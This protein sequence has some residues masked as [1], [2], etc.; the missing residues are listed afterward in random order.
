MVDDRELILI[1]II[2]LTV[3]MLQK[4]NDSRY[5]G[6]YK[7]NNRYKDI[8]KIKHDMF[9][10][11]F[12]HLFI[13]LLSNSD[14]PLYNK[15]EFLQSKMGEVMIIAVAIFTYYQLI[16]PYFIHDTDKYLNFLK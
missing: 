9:K 12:I 10:F 11:T 1:I 8:G 3:G 14:Q 15:D 6:P 2:L 16:E 7:K 13:Y 4:H 5:K